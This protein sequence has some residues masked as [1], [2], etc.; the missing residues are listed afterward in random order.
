LFDKEIEDQLDITDFSFTGFSKIVIN[1]KIKYV[2]GDVTGLVSE[3]LSYY[4]EA[5]LPISI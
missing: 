2:E 3:I 1:K 5:S 4:P